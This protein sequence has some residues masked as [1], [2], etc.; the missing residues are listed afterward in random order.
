MM[1]E[2]TYGFGLAPIVTEGGIADPDRF[3]WECDCEICKERYKNWKA[4]FD[5]EQK[6]LR[7]EE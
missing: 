3:T 7:G 2:Q 4:N 6:Q 1:N 5:A